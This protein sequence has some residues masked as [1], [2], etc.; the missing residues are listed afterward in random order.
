MPAVGL[1]IAPYQGNETWILPI[2][3]TF[4]VGRDGLVKA[5]YIDPDHRR[6]MDLDDIG[7][8]SSSAS[9][10]AATN[11]IAGTYADETVITM[12]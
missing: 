1:D 2:P 8:H 11:Q 3:A 7:G 10:A 12:V 9:I 5:R 4:I 6:R